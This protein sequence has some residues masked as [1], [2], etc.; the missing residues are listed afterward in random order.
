MGA[1]C[2]LKKGGKHRDLARGFACHAL[3]CAG[4]L[5]LAK[6][7]P[8]IAS[9]LGEMA[10]IVDEGRVG[11]HFAAGDAEDLAAKIEE[12]SANLPAQKRM[13]GAARREYEQKYTT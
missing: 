13:R 9:T 3:F 7:A 4:V 2:A 5:Q 12:Y 1:R 8:A 11:L 6:G 10:E